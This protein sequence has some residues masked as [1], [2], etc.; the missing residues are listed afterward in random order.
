MF[1]VA[2]IQKPVLPFERQ[3]NGRVFFSKKWFSREKNEKHFFFVL[4]DPIKR[5]IAYN[6][7][8]DSPLPT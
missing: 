6:L 8:C 4:T 5:Y 3:L 1:R 2:K 7:N